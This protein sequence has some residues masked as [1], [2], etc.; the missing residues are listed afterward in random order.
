[1][2][3]SRRSFLRTTT[4]V[5]AALAVPGVSLARPPRRRLR[6]DKLRIGVIGTANQAGWNISQLGSE[7][8]VALCDVDANY[9]EQAAAAIPDVKKFRDFRE[10]LSSPL[11]L[12]AVL[13]ATPDHIHAPASA[14]ALRAGKHVYCEKPLTHTVSE[15]R[16]LTELARE[17]KV[18]T[19][20]GIQIHAEPNYRRVVELVRS[21][22]IG[23]VKEVHVWVGRSWGGGAYGA[24]AQVPSHLDWNLWQGPAPE[25]E[26]CEGI[27]PGNWRRYWNY[28][29]GTLGDMACHHMDLA[30]WAMELQHPTSVHAEGPAVDAVGTPEWLTVRYE[31]PA[32]A[33]RAACS[34]TWYDGGKHA[35]VLEP[36][37]NADGTPVQWGDGTLFV[38]ETGKILADY[39]QHRL[40]REDKAVE[41]TAPARTIPNSIGHHAEWFKAIREGTPTTC[42]FDYAGP[43]T[44]AVLLGNVAYRTGKKLEWDA[45]K[46]RAVGVPEAA[47]LITHA[48]RAGWTL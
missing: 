7:Q 14:M 21:G 18:R 39:G 17:K 11:D 23:A 13:V 37:K 34:L 28:G 8:I 43:L 10:M 2:K 35:P 26:Y 19:Q 44:E 22:A 48:Y 4:A 1:M 20:M 32:R 6:A 24:A 25:H 46:M 40:F 45:A 27:H 47:K 33:G 5:A 12:D 16:L 30:F 41:F 29:T 31:H 15:A 38:G 42:G 36:L 3:L 9:L